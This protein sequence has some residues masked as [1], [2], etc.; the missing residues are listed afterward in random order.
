MSQQEM[1]MDMENRDPNNINDHLGVSICY[2]AGINSLRITRKCH[3]QRPQINST[4]GTSVNSAKPDQAP[5]NAVS[6]QVLHC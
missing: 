3:N 1:M 4:H 5:H 6:S 2:I